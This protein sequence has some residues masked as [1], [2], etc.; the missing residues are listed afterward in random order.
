M[1]Y[2]G[3]IQDN[4]DLV[5]KEYVDNR[6][7]VTGVKGN[8][9]S[10]YRTGNVNI[11][12]DN[13]GAQPT[14][15]SGTNIKTINNESLL[16]S[17]NIS[18]SGGTGA[19]TTWYGTCTNSATVSSKIVT[20]SGYTLTKGAIISVLFSYASSVGAFTLNVNST[21]AK[22]VYKGSSTASSINPLKWNAGTVVTFMYDGSYYKY[23]SSSS[24][25]AESYDGNIYLDCDITAN[26]INSDGDI[27][28][29]GTITGVPYETDL[30]L[31]SDFALYTSG[32]SVLF[33]CTGNVCS[34]TGT[35]K[36]TKTLTG[37]D[38]RVTIGTIPNGYYPKRDVQVVSHG[39]GNA[40][41]LLQINTSGVVSFSRY[42]NQTITTA[43]GYT[44]ATTSV[45]L[46]L[47]AIWII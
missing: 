18:I 39:S 4:K 24:E 19:I 29:S 2:L 10:N 21:G 6:S 8:S 22:A 9:E 11:T 31:S 1:K 34:L 15:V 13:I 36:P 12:A 25:I 40:V 45:W 14:L 35:I 38:T 47:H 28:S 44:S 30:T 26:N 20:C 3:K 23:L 5:T 27:T 42:R 43:S 17:G 32:S 41:W 37:S 46:P 33:Q 7:G 16:G